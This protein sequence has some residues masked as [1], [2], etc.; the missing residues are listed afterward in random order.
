MHR[1]R[2]GVLA[3]ML[4]ATLVACDVHEPVSIPPGATEVHIELDAERVG[5]T[6][7]SVPPGEV[8]LV[9]E[10]PGQAWELVSR[11]SAAT[12]MRSP[13]DAAQV[14]RV[15]AGDLQSTTIELFQV[16]CAPDDWTAESRWEGCG[17]VTRLTLRPGLYLIR[18]PGGE[19]GVVVPSAVLEV[20]G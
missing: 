20:G 17:N 18:T 12:D 16:T 4:A 19:P 11:G 2:I 7:A 10:G 1:P 5:L 9:L 3:L 8:Y 15:R 6:P 13:L 14:E